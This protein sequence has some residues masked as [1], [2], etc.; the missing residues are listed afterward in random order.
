MN[1]MEERRDI[2]PDDVGRWMGKREAFGAMGSRCYAADVE[3]LSRIRDRRLWTC[4]SSSWEEFCKD[5]LHI[6]R[7]SADR[8]IGY[9]RQYGPA[10]FAIR[11]LTHI[12]AADY[13]LI[14]D[15]I[16][17]QGVLVDGALIPLS[18]DDALA[19]AVA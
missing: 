1:E 3:I 4:C 16:S 18:Q 15:Q 14:A 2:G 19:D 13:H 11:Q 6:A 10:F 9:L 5:H 12:S 17:E 8:E 7:R